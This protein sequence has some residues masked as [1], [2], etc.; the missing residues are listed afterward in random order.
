MKKTIENL[1]DQI[2][3]TPKQVKMFFG[4][5]LVAILAVAFVLPSISGKML[6][7]SVLNVKTESKVDGYG[8]G[9]VPLGSL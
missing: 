4:V 7:G 9:S 6:Q 8:Y 3:S 2:K 5:L 1:F